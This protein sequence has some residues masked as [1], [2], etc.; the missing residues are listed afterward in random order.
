MAARLEVKL[1][2]GL[3]S[4][5]AALFLTKWVHTVEIGS[6]TKPAS[7]DEQCILAQIKNILIEMEQPELNSDTSLAAT[8]SKAW[9]TFF[10]DVSLWLGNS[11]RA[12]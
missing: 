3:T 5:S 12:T 11:Q 9:S 1:E 4:C 7:E 10:L 6:A 8:L 2:K